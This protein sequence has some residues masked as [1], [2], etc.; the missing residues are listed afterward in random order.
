MT[1]AT[2]VEE[3]IPL[4]VEAFDKIRLHHFIVRLKL[5]ESLGPNDAV[6]LDFVENY[7]FSS[8]IQLKVSLG[9]T[10]RPHYILLKYIKEIQPI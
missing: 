2:P 5:K 8:N 7:R 6:V 9:T 1:I 10:R 4:V 3:F